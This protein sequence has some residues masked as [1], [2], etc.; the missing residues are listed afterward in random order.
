MCIQRWIRFDLELWLVHRHAQIRVENFFKPSILLVH[1]LPPTQ[2]FNLFDLSPLSLT[3]QILL[4]FLKLLFNFVLSEHTD[5]FKRPQFILRCLQLVLWCWKRPTKCIVLNHS[6]FTG[7]RTKIVHLLSGNFH[8]WCHVKRL[9]HTPA[10]SLA[11]DRFENTLGNS[12][13]NSCW[14]RWLLCPANFLAKVAGFSCI[15]VDGFH[16]RLSLN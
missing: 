5:F 6:T 10:V 11:D 12:G 2:R 4:Q 16:T 7:F 15:I 8:A 3:E 13:A 14:P 9:V 1:E